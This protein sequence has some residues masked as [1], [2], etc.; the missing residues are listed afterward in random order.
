MALHYPP[1]D[2]PSRTAIWFNFLGMLRNDNEDMDYGEIVERVDEL[3][4]HEMN[5]RQIRNAVTTARQLAL[6][7][8]VPLGWG[9][10]EMAMGAAADFDGHLRRVGAMAE[11][12]WVM[13]GGSVVGGGGGK[14]GE[15]GVEME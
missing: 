5:G 12:D 14:G 7:E 2:A 3:A 1:L 8:G 10:V 6:F 4:A 13:E 9:H 11:E 15:G